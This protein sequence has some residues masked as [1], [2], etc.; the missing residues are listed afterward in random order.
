M[1]FGGDPFEYREFVVNFRDHIESQVSDDS[2][3][4]AR[5]PAQCVGMAKD[6]IKSCVNLPVGQ[7]YSEAWKTL[8]KNFGQPH[9]VAD[10]LMKGNLRRIDAPSLMEFARRLEDTKRVLTSMGPLY[11]SRLDNEDTILMLMKKLPDEGLKRKWTDIAGDLI[12]SK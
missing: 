9:M 5:L 4:L 11:V 7:R 3:R 12:C 10:A 1:K 8:S 6:A 2:Q